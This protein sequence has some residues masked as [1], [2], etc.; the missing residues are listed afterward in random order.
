[1]IIDHWSTPGGCHD[2]C[3]ACSFQAREVRDLRSARTAY[4][5]GYPGAAHGILNDL[6]HR[7]DRSHILESHWNSLNLAVDIKAATEAALDDYSAT[8]ED[9]EPEWEQPEESCSPHIIVKGN[10][11]DGL[12]FLGPFQSHD[13]AVEHAEGGDEDW[14]VAKLDNTGIPALT[15]HD[16]S[17]ALLTEFINKFRDAVNDEDNINGGDAVDAIVELVQKFDALNR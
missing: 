10:P 14:W 4:V 16:Q 1:M 11:V 5:R 6:L 7:E 13:A 8:Y 9:V 15:T 3:P 17:T 12:W 2:D